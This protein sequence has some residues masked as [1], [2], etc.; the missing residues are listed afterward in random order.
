MIFSV[1]IYHVALRYGGP[2]EGGWYEAGDPVFD[3]GFWRHV[4]SFADEGEAERYRDELE[5]SKVA[6]LNR[7]RPPLSSVNSSGLYRARVSE[8]APAAF[9]AERPRYE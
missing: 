9:P 7:G 3:R 2:E 8:G 4:R 6:R 1:A 5:R